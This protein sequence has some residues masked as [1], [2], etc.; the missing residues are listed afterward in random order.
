[1]K[2]MKLGTKPDTF[3]TEEAT[4]SVLSDVPSDLIIQINNTKYLLH[5]FPLLLK[6]G[7][8]QRLC[9]DSPSSSPASGASPSS[10]LILPDFPGGEAAF[11][12]CAKF[13]YNISIT[14]SAHNFLPALSAA[15]YLLMTDSISRPNFLPKL[16]TFFLSFILPNWKDSVVTLA[17]SSSTSPPFSDPTIIRPLIDSIVSKILTPASQ[18]TWSFTYS[19]RI[20]N[21]STPKDWWTEDIAE[22]DLNHFRTIVSCLK[23]SGG[24]PPAL[25]GEALHV[26]SVKNLPDP[27]GM[28]EL[29]GKERR[30]L[31]AVAS[32]IPIE[33]G[34]VSGGFLMRLLKIGIL[35]GASTSVR[36]E[37]VRRAGR[38]LDEVSVGDLVFYV[39]EGVVDIGVVE[40]VVESF[41]EGFRRRRA[42]EKDERERMRRVAKVFDEYLGFVAGDREMTVEKF[43]ELSTLLPE[44]AREEHDGLYRAI[45]TFLEEH[46]DLSKAD[47]KRLCQMIDCRKL[48]P[49]ARSQAIANDRLP[50]RTLVQLLFV[51]Q[52]RMAGTREFRGSPTAHQTVEG[53][54]HRRRRAEEMTERGRPSTGKKG[55]GSGSKPEHKGRG[56]VDVEKKKKVEKRLG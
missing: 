47:K 34:A 24:L 49:E 35:V 25:I 28:V 13:C 46:Q 43:V 7:L 32:M 30:V 40:A 14:L 10:P 36:A 17:S 37:L 39:R 44:V 5:K 1:M 12:L 50:L 19:R 2:Y 54:D 33:D 55:E 48:S 8:L 52:E 6:C 4:R 41:L 56:E 27:N 26:Y 23:S 45:D 18:V 31:E 21:S 29:R 20:S 11:E 51:E 9:S 42:V 3:Y 16:H 38:Q 22:L 15:S 53:E